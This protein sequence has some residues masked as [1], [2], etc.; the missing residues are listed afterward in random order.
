[1]YREFPRRLSNLFRGHDELA[2]FEL[3]P[4]L[5]MS[6]AAVPSG[7]AFLAPSYRSPQSLQMN[8]GFQRELRPGMVLSV[9]YLRNVGTHYLLSTD[10]NHSGDVAYFDS[11]LRPRLFKVPLPTAASRTSMPLSLPVVAMPDSN[12]VFGGTINPNPVK[13][14]WPLSQRWVWIPRPTLALANALRILPL[15]ASAPSAV[16]IRP[17]VP[18]RSCNQLD[19]PS[20][21]DWTL[22]SSKTRRIHSEASSI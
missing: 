14:L 20:T 11:G 13:L 17:S 9:D 7:A 21:T 10:V 3:H 5:L 22:N 6:N 15:V 16:S 12:T 2:K 4:E 18:F 8:V 1:M 19:V